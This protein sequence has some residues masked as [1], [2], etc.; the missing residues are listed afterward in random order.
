MRAIR[1]EALRFA[2]AGVA[3]LG[4]DVALLYLALALGLGWY[5]GRVL[6]FLGA[7]WLTWQINRR[8]TFQGRRDG[9][10]WREWWRYLAAMSGGGLVNYAV[11]SGALWLL[12]G[13][14]P[15]PPVLLPLLAVGCGSLAGMVLNFVSA[16]F[17]VFQR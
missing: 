2:V 17:F 16:K 10:P 12:R 13:W 5:A 7:V 14:T 6:S 8:Y 3:G 9:S 15:L 1:R 4:A 11:Y